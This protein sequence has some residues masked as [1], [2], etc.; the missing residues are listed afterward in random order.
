MPSHCCPQMNRRGYSAFLGLFYNGTSL[1]HEGSALQTNHFPKAP[2]PKTITL[3]VRSSNY[4]FGGSICIWFISVQQGLGTNFSNRCYII[5]I[6][7]SFF[8]F[9]HTVKNKTSHTIVQIMSCEV[10]SPIYYKVCL[11]TCES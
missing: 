6:S 11:N 8:T 7:L 9:W 1:S 2:L 4:G 5:S 3:G 10:C